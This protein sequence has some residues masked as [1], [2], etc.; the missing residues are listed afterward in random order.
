[1]D[2]SRCAWPKGYGS[3]YGSNGA[4]GPKSIPQYFDGQLMYKMD[5]GKG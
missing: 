4:P 2:P 5:T 1:M 3:G